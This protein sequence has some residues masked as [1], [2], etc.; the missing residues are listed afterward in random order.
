MTF[1]R[2]F[3]PTSIQ[4]KTLDKSHN[5]YCD[6]QNAE[7][8]DYHPSRGSLNHKAINQR[9]SQSSDDRR[10]AKATLDWKPLAARV[11]SL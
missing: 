2:N 1:D 3:K 10:A 4:E 6:A 5:D 7:L 8:I 11:A 9:A